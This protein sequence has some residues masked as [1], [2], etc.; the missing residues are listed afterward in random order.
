MRSTASAFGVRV[1]ILP[2]SMVMENSPSLF[3]IVVR[4]AR[5]LCL[6]AG[7]REYYRLSGGEAII[8]MDVLDSEQQ[9]AGGQSNDG[10]RRAG[11]QTQCQNSTRERE[12]EIELPAPTGCHFSPS[13]SV[14][15]P[16]PK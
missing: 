14:R 6:A 2:W 11:M 8:P 4:R 3:G 10:C 13:I 12:N 16:P 5:S 7:L 1:A 15:R 9:G